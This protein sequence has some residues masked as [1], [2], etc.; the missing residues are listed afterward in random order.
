MR[1]C[2]LCLSLFEVVI[3]WRNEHSKSSVSFETRCKY[4]T[5]CGKYKQIMKIIQQKNGN[6]GMGIL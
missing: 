1:I 5:I 4:T 3:R 2:L 6:M